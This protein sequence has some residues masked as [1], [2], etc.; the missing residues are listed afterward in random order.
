MDEEPIARI[1]VVIE[2][3]TDIVVVKDV[4]ENDY[5]MK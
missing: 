5:N 1:V 2:E 3:H 4:R